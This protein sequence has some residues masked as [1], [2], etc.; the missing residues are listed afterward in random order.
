MSCKK[1]DLLFA[2]DHFIGDGHAK[3]MLDTRLG[4][5]FTLC[6][7]FVLGIFG[8]TTFGQDNVK[9]TQ[10]LIPESILEQRLDNINN[11]SFFGK[12][13]ISMEAYSLLANASCAEAIGNDLSLA[14]DMK[15]KSEVNEADV[16]MFNMGSI[17]SV[18]VTC[19]VGSRL[20]GTSSLLFSLSDSFQSIRYNVRADSWNG[21]DPDS[22]VEN[23]IESSPNGSLAGDKSNP[24]DINFQ[25][26]RS[27]YQNKARPILL[28]FYPRD[29]PSHY[30]L[31]LTELK[32][33]L[34]TDA[35]SRTGKHYVSFNFETT[36]S[37]FT[38]EESDKVDLVSQLSRMFTL[39]L[40]TL[41]FFR[42]VKTYVE[43]LIDTVI[44]YV[45]RAK[46][47]PV[48]ED[49]KER[50]NIL[51]ERHEVS[52]AKRLSFKAGHESGKEPSRRMSMLMSHEVASGKNPDSV[53][54][55]SIELASIENPLVKKAEELNKIE[56]SDMKALMKKVLAN[57][58][59][60]R[61]DNERL[62]RK[63]AS[64]DATVVRLVSIV[65]GKTDGSIDKVPL[66]VV[67]DERAG[68]TPPL[69]VGWQV[70]E[71]EGGRVYYCRPD[72]T[73]T[74]EPP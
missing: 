29:E 74:W 56:D 52:G 50:V 5:A 9:I 15:C 68:A 45:S 70:F 46:G 10:A 7:P 64:L 21:V 8:V 31:Q 17:C 67:A 27:R 38:K 28:S 60:M 16:A 18:G 48:P 37:V 30:G 66:D 6:I 35:A 55:S 1:S 71:A 13:Y 3:R 73:T 19:D 32:A 58:E 39:L 4:A 11:V 59:R 49:V 72:G 61:K 25:L 22:L 33:V 44:L 53:N 40:S 41:A 26:T 51:E 62:R 23:T 63:V 34:K 65:E 12:L 47:I 43:L 24:T 20:A 54:G 14:H 57:Y 42:L 2:G 36:G 69:P